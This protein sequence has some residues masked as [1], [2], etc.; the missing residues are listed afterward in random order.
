M[1]SISPENQ[2]RIR[3][4]LGAGYWNRIFMGTETRVKMLQ[5]IG[6]SKEWVV[7]PDIACLLVD[8]QGSVLRAAI[9]AVHRLLEPL[10]PMDLLWL[11]HRIRKVDPS[12][13]DAARRWSKLTVAHVSR[14]AKTDFAASLCGLASFD[15]DGHVREAAVQAL[16]MLREGHE[17][18]YLLIRLN[19]WVPEIRSCVLAAVRE[20]LVPEYAAHYLHHLRLVL[21]L[22]HQGRVDKSFIEAIY[23]LLRQPECRNVLH[24]GMASKDRMLRRAS[25]QLAASV[26]EPW[27]GLIIRKAISDPD[28]VA[29]SWAVRRFL[30]AIPDELL[31]Q[32]AGSLLKDRYRPV[33]QDA[34]CAMASRLPECAT[35]P[36]RLALLDSSASVRAI[37]RHFLSKTN[38]EFGPY[39]SAVIQERKSNMLHAAIRG[40]SEV[41]QK[42]DVAQVLPFL[43]AAEP[44]LRAA[45]ICA[46]G[47][48][49]PEAFLPE[50]LLALSDD[51]ASVSREAVRACLP[52]ARLFNVDTLWALYQKDPRFFVRKHVLMLLQRFG[53]WERLAPLLFACGDS[54]PMIS[55]L[56]RTSV[57]KWLFTFNSSFA[58]PTV[59]QIQQARQALK[60]CMGVL[61]PKIAMDIS[62]CVAT[63]EK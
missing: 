10:D 52:K 39:Y 45:A 59:A 56:A 25:F 32:I 37:A 58:E 55:D 34:L 46:L 9:E 8:S 14:F 31:L 22:E 19:D 12:N 42:S 6:F 23:N 20:R 62:S 1:R 29:R 53:K 27:R 33:R 4:L 18:P 49:D 54:N 30:P 41:G 44:R 17:L 3:R 48:L 61:D 40:L 51:H 13:Q 2:E 60:G 63:F 7:I 47:R 35:E 26:E 11:D 15:A 50:L 16:C 24:A 38:F 36:L 57:C 21:H 43:M 28:P 5:E